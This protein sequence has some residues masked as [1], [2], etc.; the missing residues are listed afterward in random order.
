MK[1]LKVFIIMSCVLLLG[2]LSAG[3]YVWYAIQEYQKSL[4]TPQEVSNQDPV[5]IE[6][7]VVQ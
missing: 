1:S 3:V 7:N 2:A 5:A 6:E 4:T